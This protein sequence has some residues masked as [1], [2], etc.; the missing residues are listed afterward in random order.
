MV[1]GKHKPMAPVGPPDSADYPNLHWARLGYTIPLNFLLTTL[2]CY[3]TVLF[4]KDC[5]PG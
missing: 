2:A 1:F 3:S 4:N 5:E